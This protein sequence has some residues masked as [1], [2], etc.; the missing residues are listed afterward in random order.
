MKG[1]VARP[2][3]IKCR[4][5]R[6]CL[7]A[8]IGSITLEAAAPQ[9]GA[10]LESLRAEAAI[11]GLDWLGKAL[12]EIGREHLRAMSNAAGLPVRATGSK[13]WLSVSDLRAG[14]LAYLAPETERAGGCIGNEIM[15]EGIYLNY[16]VE[17]R[18]HFDF[19]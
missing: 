4:I 5:A 17:R 14:L 12:A 1:R 8:M 7:P 15:P 3:K 2:C 13:N 9:P 10:N 18:C 19:A 16:R 11:R 6:A